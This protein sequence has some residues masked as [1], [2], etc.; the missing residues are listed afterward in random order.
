MIRTANSPKGMAVARAG[1]SWGGQFADFDNDGYLDLY[2]SNGYESVPGD[3]ET[4][5]DL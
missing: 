2:V 4:E 1:W 5:V 3:H